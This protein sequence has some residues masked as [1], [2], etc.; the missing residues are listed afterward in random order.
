MQPRLLLDHHRA[1]KN[2]LEHSSV[3]SKRL[4]ANATLAGLAIHHLKFCHVSN[5]K[6]SCWTD[7]MSHVLS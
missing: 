6:P 1:H 3:C 4:I 7:M 2:N 5:F